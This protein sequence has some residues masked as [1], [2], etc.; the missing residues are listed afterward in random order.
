MELTDS[1]IR[2]FSD[3]GRERDLD[4]RSVA[5][6]LLTFALGEV[7][8]SESA[9]KRF[10]AMVSDLETPSPPYPTR[11]RGRRKADA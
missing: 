2:Q 7:R 6:A 9:R 5:A 11:R 1:E 10:L 4:F 8:S 3:W